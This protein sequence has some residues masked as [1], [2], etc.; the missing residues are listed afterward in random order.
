MRTVLPILLVFVTAAASAD[1][2]VAPTGKATNPGTA[3][4]SFATVFQARDAIRAM[5][6]A[7]GL[8][9]RGLTVW[10]HAG[11]Y[12]FTEPLVLESEDSG[13]PKAPSVYRS[14]KG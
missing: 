8:P 6:A 12:E 13:A 7:D 10:L 2:Y 11:V 1:L 14:V 5:K 9:E 3:E 4:A